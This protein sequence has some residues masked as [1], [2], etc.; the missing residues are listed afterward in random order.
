M[1][2][3]ERDWA[4]SSPEEHGL[5][6]RKLQAAMDVIARISGEQG[7]RQAVVI[8]DGRMVWRGDDIDNLHSVWSCTKSILSLT[9]G[10]LTEDGR[11]SLDTPAAD[12]YPPLEELYPTVTLRHMATFT[13][14]YRPRE[15]GADAAPFVPA[16][17]HFAPGEKFHYS[18][19]PYL[20]ALI[21]TKIAG[22]PLRDLFRR[23]VAEP[24]GLDASAWRWGD[25][26]EFD[27]LTGLRNVPVCGGSGL[28]DRGVSMTARAMARVG[29]L[30]AQGG[31]WAGRQIVARQW[32]EQATRPQVP[33]STPPYEP[34]AWYRRLPGT[35]GYYWWTNGIDSL[36]KRM[37]PSAPER[38]FA[39]Q[40]HLNNVCFVIPPWRMVVVRLGMD[41]AIDNDLYEEFFAALRQAVA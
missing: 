6:G 18:W 12:L 16:S 14:G 11:C 28:Y 32:V 1:V 39:M 10:L 34:A 31:L 37:W 29:W 4:E 22:E 40:G 15:A 26:G 17:P 25:W 21:L 7:V 13:S 30:M 5:D 20:L 27:R 33:A 3:P 8:R 24:I 19:E 35:Y 36:G 38:T 41:L 9:L 23:R 2:L